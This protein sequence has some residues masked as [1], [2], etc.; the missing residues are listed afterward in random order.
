MATSADITSYNVFIP[1]DV[2]PT[3]E[4]KVKLADQILINPLSKR[5]RLSMSNE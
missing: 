3:A 1:D 5:T 2:I 4:T